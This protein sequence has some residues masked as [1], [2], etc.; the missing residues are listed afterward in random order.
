MLF[1]GDDVAAPGDEVCAIP[2][3]ASATRIGTIEE[4]FIGFAFP[5]V[6]LTANTRL[7]FIHSYQHRILA[8]P[9]VHD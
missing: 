5:L 4:F 8:K 9:T 2:D 3:T 1:A 6:P 7:V